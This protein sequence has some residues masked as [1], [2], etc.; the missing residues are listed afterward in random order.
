[1]WHYQLEGHTPPLKIEGVNPLMSATAHSVEFTLKG[2]KL[3]FTAH[4][5]RAEVNTKEGPL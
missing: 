2:E 1:M 3:D 5:M 4:Q